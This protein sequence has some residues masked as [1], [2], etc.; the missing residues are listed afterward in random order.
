[1]TQPELG[2]PRRSHKKSTNVSRRFANKA[3]HLATRTLELLHLLTSPFGT[4]C[5]LL[6]CNDM[7]AIGG[8]SDIGT[9]GFA[10]AAECPS[11]GLI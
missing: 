5:R 7:S 9:S 4:K 8:Y 3:E 6:Q 11:I 10:Y 2:K 1:M